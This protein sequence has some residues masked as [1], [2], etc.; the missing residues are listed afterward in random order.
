[1]DIQNIIALIMQFARPDSNID[2]DW[3]EYDL[4][5]L[6]LQKLL[7]YCQ[8]FALAKLN[9]PIFNQKI[10][11]WPHG[12]VVVEV[13]EQ[14]KKYGRE[15]IIIDI[16]EDSVG[17]IKEPDFLLIIQEVYRVYGQ[18]SAYKLRQKTH[19]EPPWKNT[20]RMHEITH[21]KLK[22]YFSLIVR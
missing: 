9:K 16:K 2:P 13:Y 10:I 22:D 17:L 20:L 1:M 18:Y 11:A 5:N 15:P 21:A 19:D 8:G 14:F 6:K 4:T 7:Y 3:D 12:P